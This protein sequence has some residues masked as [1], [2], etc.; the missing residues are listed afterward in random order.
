M[1]IRQNYLRNAKKSG[2]AAAVLALAGVAVSPWVILPGIGS[3]LPSNLTEL[4]R[5]FSQV[6]ALDFETGRYTADLDG[7][8]AIRVLD[9]PPNDTARL[10]RVRF[11][12]FPDINIGFLFG[13]KRLLVVHADRERR[14][15][16]GSVI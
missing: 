7:D 5:P 3:W 12:A 4:E 2:L 11:A 14:S 8:G 9:L 6:T 15:S 10:T 13:G 1:V 16:R